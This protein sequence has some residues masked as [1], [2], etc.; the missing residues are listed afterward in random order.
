MYKLLSKLNKYHFFLGIQIVLLLILGTY[1]FAR[2]EYDIPVILFWPIFISI[3]FTAFFII[4]NFN[5]RNKLILTLIIL[6]LSI[7]TIKLLGY[8]E[9]YQMP[10]QDDYFEIG[11]ASTIIEN[12]YW[13]IDAGTGR[14]EGYYGAFPGIHFFLSSFSVLTGLDIHI[15]S[16]YLYWPFLLIMFVL[17]SYILFSK[18]FNENKDQYYLSAI[19]TFFY[20]SSIGMMVIHISRRTFADLFALIAIY[21]LINIYIRKNDEKTPYSILFIISVI[22]VSMSHHFTGYILVFVITVILLITVKN[23]FWDIT[24]QVQDQNFR[25]LL[26]SIYNNFWNITKQGLNKNFSE[27]IN[28]VLLTLSIVLAW[29]IYVAFFVLNKD[30]NGA[31]NVFTMTLF[32]TTESKLAVMSNYNL[33][34]QFLPY[35]S[36]VIF[37]L[38]ASAGILYIRKR[39][40][41][42]K[43]SNLRLFLLIMAVFGVLIYASS[44]ILLRTQ[45]YFISLSSMW[46][47]GL[48]LSIACVYG[49][50]YIY[51]KCNI[52][53]KKFFTILF[54]LIMVIYSGNIIMSYGARFIDKPYNSDLTLEDMRLYNNQYFNTGEWMSLNTD[55]TANISTDVSGNPIYGGYFG[56]RVVGASGNKYIFEKPVLYSNFLKNFQYIVTSKDIIRYSSSWLGIPLE[57]YKL[58]KFD[59]ATFITKVYDNGNNIVYSRND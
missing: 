8:P 35:V 52:N 55:P 46:F 27:N 22:M 3:I 39:K 14:A 33:I 5:S 40:N 13:N 42:F 11:Y 57:P 7:S 54:V 2:S 10:G 51:E 24:K 1:M 15:L 47:A 48:F 23:N 58:S 59:N 56:L 53:E 30:L 29:L 34:E 9:I 44:A 6:I 32:Q 26:V 49:V 25:G 43:Y 45:F 41:L 50:Y 4:N 28:R 31:I 37:L 17:I 21:S 16:K 18:V 36:Q 38:L 19:A 20:I 12:G